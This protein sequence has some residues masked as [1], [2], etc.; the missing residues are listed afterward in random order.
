MSIRVTDDRFKNIVRWFEHLSPQTLDSIDVV[1]AMDAQFRDPFN[2]M[3]GRV[4]IRSVYQHMF[5]SLDSPRFMIHNVVANGQQAFMVWDFSFGLR[6]RSMR[7]H[8]CTHFVIDEAGLITL[9][10]DYWDAA[11]ELYEQL[12]VI[13]PLLRWLKRR[14]TIPE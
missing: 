9:H 10:R 4:R 7:I 6:G 5:E 14:I 12:P 3:R 11:E 1:Y 2:D 13:G 8:G